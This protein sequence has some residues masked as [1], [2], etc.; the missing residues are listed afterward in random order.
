MELVMASFPGSAMTTALAAFG[1]FFLTGVGSGGG[2]AV[3]GSPALQQIV[4]LMIMSP[5]SSARAAS[6]FGMNASAPS[7]PV[8]WVTML[9][10]F[11][12]YM[13]EACPPILPARSV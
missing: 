12:A 10:M 7:L 13:A 11:V 8:K 1:G 5:F 2:G 6:T 3:I 9:S 4:D